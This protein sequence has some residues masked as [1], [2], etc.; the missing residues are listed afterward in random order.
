PT[1][2]IAGP[3]T[4]L[5]RFVA[6]MDL[7]PVR[8][9]LYVLVANANESASIQ[10]FPAT[11]N[12]DVAPLRSISGPATLLF[13]AGDIDFDAARDEVLVAS[14]SYNAPAA[15]LLAFPRLASGDAAPVRAISG[16]ATGV[17]AP[18]GWYS[19]ISLPL[20]EL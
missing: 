17:V 3:A 10:V 19:V 11:A 6:G 20:T 4:G 14:G 8:G 1:R 9:E 16:A 2:R 7:D 5:G 18:D 13:N 12:G 15:R